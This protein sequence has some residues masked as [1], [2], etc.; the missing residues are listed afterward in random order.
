MYRYTQC[1]TSDTNAAPVRLISK[2]KNQSEFTQM[3]CLGGEN[4]GGSGVAKG[5]E[6]EILDVFGLPRTWY[7]FSR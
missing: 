6:V 7:M 5:F 2:L 4:A 3:A 1:C